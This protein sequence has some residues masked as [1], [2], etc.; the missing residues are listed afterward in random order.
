M[1]TTPDPRYFVGSANFVGRYD[2][3]VVVS[4]E[5]ESYLEQKIYYFNYKFCTDCFY[6]LDGKE[7]LEEERII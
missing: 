6:K 3:S 2:C 5:R 4:I 1:D 7:Y